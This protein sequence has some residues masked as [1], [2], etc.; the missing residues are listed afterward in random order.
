M[1]D[2]SRHFGKYVTGYDGIHGSIGY[3][4]RNLE[5]MRILELGSSLDMAVRNTF[6]KKRVS[7]LIAYTLGPFKTQ[8]IT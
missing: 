4:V 8:V 2:I 6:F 1:A 5:G 7:Q 3:A